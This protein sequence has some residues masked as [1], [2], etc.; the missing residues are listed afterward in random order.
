MHQI[1]T[2]KRDKS[3]EKSGESIS[4]NPLSFEEV[5][6]DLLKI[7]LVKNKKLAKD[8]SKVKEKNKW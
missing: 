1:E 2:M 3:K 5:L 6:E 4:L 8:K 7:K